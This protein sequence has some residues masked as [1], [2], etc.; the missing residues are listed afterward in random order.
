VPHSKRK[1]YY[2]ERKVV[3]LLNKDGIPAER[4]PLSGA[5]GRVNGLDLRGDIDVIGFKAEVKARAN[6]SGFTTLEKWM[7]ENDFLV[8]RRDRQMPFVAMN[9]ETYIKLMKAYMAQ[10]GAIAGPDVDGV[11]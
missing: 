3:D 10:H 8:L 1:G 4:V 9:W 2:N 5:L 11:E 6:G 7:G